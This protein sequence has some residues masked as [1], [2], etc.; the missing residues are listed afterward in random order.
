MASIIL[1]SGQAEARA[2]RFGIYGGRYVPETLV[3]ALVELEAAYEAA[4]AD[5]AFQT[6][7]AGLLK[8]F[9]DDR[10]RCILQNG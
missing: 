3:A 10:H 1:P 4:K 2:G 5:A 9:A 7:L 6:E 8:D